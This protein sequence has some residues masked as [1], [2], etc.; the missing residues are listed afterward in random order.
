MDS[1]DNGK[2]GSSAPAM[3]H[4]LP[5][6][7]PKKID[8]SYG[9]LSGAPYPSLMISLGYNAAYTVPSKQLHKTQRSL[10]I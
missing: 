10:H 8:E 3:H 9:C 7:Q 5:N 6:P 2:E 4:A 1:K